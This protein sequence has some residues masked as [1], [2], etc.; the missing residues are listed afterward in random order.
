M[1][2]IGFLISKCQLIISIGTFFSQSCSAA[3]SLCVHSIIVIFQLSSIKIETG[4]LIQFCLMSFRKSSQVHLAVHSQYQVSLSIFLIQTQNSSE[5]LLGFLNN[6]V[7]S[8][9][10]FFINS[11]ALLYFLASSTSDFNSVFTLGSIIGFLIHK[12]FPIC[13]SSII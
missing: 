10:I 11:S 13:H 6:S 3:R 8:V 9:F 4:S 2:V 12:S 5:I 1:S 7:G